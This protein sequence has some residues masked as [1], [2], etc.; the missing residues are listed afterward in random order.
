MAEILANVYRGDLIESNHYGNLAVVAKSGQNI[1]GVGNSQQI[2]YW[3]SAAKPF[4]ALPVVFSG[5][6]D[7]YGIG[8]EEL[9]IM[10]ASHN[11]EEQH[12]EIVKGILDKIGLDESFLLCGIHSPYHKPTAKQII[13]S[14]NEPG[15]L[16]NNC[17][18][19]HAGILTLCQYYGWSLEDYLEAEHP[20]QQ[21]FLGVISEVTDYPEAKI[22]LGV[23]G[24]GVVVFGLPLENMALAYARLADP[25]SLSTRYQ[26][27]A[28]KIAR[29]MVDNPG[30]VAG[31][32]RFNTDLMKVT[33]DRLVAKMGAEGVFCIGVNK[34]M[35]IAVKIADGNRRA[36]PPVIV[37]TLHQL[38]ILSEKELDELEKYHIPRVL[39][40]HRRKIG[41][42]EPDFKLEY[43]QS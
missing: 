21:L 32:D 28:G 37:E 42:I 12:V 9:A 18:G 5:A 2:T 43:N 40:N 7:R 36:I 17:S 30:L 33:G 34:Q 41:F 25:E 20:V 11:G 27:A 26:E 6:A 15:R 23:D 3:R 29:A 24:C 39:N 16:H 22:H 1:A 10:A 4:Q 13:R 14:G 8:D 19:K 31:T 38:D 35:G